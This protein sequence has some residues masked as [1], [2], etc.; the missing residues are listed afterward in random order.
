MRLDRAVDDTDENDDAGI[1]VVPAVDQKGLQRRGAFS[2]VDFEVH[3]GEVLGIAG[4]VGSGREE[5]ARCLAGLDAFDAG[6]V[7]VGGLALISGSRSVPKCLPSGEMTCMDGPGVVSQ[8]F[9]LTSTFMPS[10]MPGDLSLL[11]S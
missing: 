9:P 3:E 4:V 1:G 7:E 10:V 5:L 6:S 2:D 11:T 8:T